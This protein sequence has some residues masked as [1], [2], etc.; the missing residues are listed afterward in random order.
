MEKM[1][2]GPGA[3]CLPKVEGITYIN[4]GA[5]GKIGMVGLETLFQQ[6]YAMGRSPGDATDAEL[7]CMARTSN[8]IPNRQ[9][10]EA[11]YALALRQA[12]TAFYAQQENKK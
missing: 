11:E 8:Y 3:C 7:V 9:S 2:P 1:T 6:L 4:L 12:Y 10:I 5:S